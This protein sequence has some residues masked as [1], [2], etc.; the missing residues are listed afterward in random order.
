MSKDIEERDVA[1]WLL[2][3]IFS[4]SRDGQYKDPKTYTK[5]PK[6]LL[7]SHRPWSPVIQERKM[8]PRVKGLL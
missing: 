8:E 5:N 1:M 6:E 4:D 7:E 3:A 2:R